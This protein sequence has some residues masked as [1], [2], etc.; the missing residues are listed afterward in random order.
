MLLAFKLVLWVLKDLCHSLLFVLMFGVKF[1]SYPK[2]NFFPAHNAV[3][4]SA[5]FA[6]NPS[7]MLCLDMP[8]EKLEGTEKSEEAEVLGSTSTGKWLHFICPLFF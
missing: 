2:I 8:S 6:P 5:I 3:V 4:T 7:L 1:L